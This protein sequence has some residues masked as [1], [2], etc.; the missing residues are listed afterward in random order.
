MV[1]IAVLFLS[2]SAL[3]DILPSAIATK[4]YSLQ[5]L[6]QFQIYS[7]N[8]IFGSALGIAATTAFI[9]VLFSAEVS[10]SNATIYDMTKGCRF[11]VD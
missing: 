4:G 3:G 5:E 11:W 10:S 8:G 6:I 7:A 1:L 2:Y 9:F